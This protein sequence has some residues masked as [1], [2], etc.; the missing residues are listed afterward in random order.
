MMK[1]FA[2]PADKAQTAISPELRREVSAAMVEDIT[3]LED[4][5]DMDLSAWKA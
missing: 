1:H 3:R 5:L 2:K 4:L